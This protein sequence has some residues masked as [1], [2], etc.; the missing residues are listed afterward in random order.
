MRADGFS[1]GALS[2]TCASYTTRIEVVEYEYEGVPHPY[3]WWTPVGTLHHRISGIYHYSLGAMQN[4]LEAVAISDTG[5]A[6]LALSE[7]STGARDL[8]AMDQYARYL[9]AQR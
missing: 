5:T 9:A 1:F 6:S 8:H 3:P 7:M 4:C 2:S